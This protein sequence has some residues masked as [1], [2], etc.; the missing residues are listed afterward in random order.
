M[1]KKTESKNKKNDDAAAR[2]VGQQQA[3][4]TAPLPTGCVNIC[5]F[6]NK[7]FKT[8]HTLP[9]MSEPQIDVVTKNTMASNGETLGKVTYKKVDVRTIYVDMY[10]RHKLR[11]AR[12]GRLIPIFDI[13]KTGAIMLSYR[14]GHFWCFEGMH[15]VV[16]AVAN[17]EE[18]L[19]AA[20]YTDETVE[21]EATMFA[22][23]DDAK[24]TIKP[25]EKYNAGIIA[26]L[27]DCVA[28]RDL[29]AKYALAVIDY[30]YRV[31]Y[32]LRAIEAARAIVQKYGVPCLDW[33]LGVMK[34]AEWL[35]AKDA[36]TAK[37]L[38][39]LA[40][41]YTTRPDPADRAAARDVLLPVLYEI[42]PDDLGAVA[43]AMSALHL[44]TRRH[45][46]QWIPPSRK[47][48]VL[49]HVRRNRQNEKG[50]RLDLHLNPVGGRILSLFRYK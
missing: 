39:S 48:H 31:T 25:I 19:M 38:Q 21:S 5:E 36:T 8:A 22:T 34:D 10:Q 32:P 6:A 49:R 42:K 40:R 33:V 24:T 46:A 18:Y 29:C 43:L 9:P 44:G 2:T 27:P 45:P 47:S 20:I 41:V 7:K 15:R 16:G 17:G 35:T 11:N 13:N 12:M 28:I 30:D 1:N 14:N 37:H 50:P 3:Q 26:Q 4:A 23:Q